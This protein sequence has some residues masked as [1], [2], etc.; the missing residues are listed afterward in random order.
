MKTAICKVVLFRFSPRNEG[1]LLNGSFFLAKA[2]GWKT[3]LLMDDRRMRE[4]QKIFPFFSCAS[5]SFPLKN[6]PGE[7]FSLLP[8]PK[9]TDMD[10]GRSRSLLFFFFFFS[11]SGN[12]DV[13]D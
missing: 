3:A 6:L 7:E 5:C 8:C 11:F 4:A 13:T 12:F 9:A 10:N 2:E 1:M